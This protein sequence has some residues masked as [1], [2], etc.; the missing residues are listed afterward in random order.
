MEGKRR[1]CRVYGLFRFILSFTANTLSSR[2]AALPPSC[3]ASRSTTFALYLLPSLFLLLSSWVY[4][5]REDVCTMRKVRSERILDGNG[6]TDRLSAKNITDRR[7]GPAAVS[8]SPDRHSRCNSR[9]RDRAIAFSFSSVPFRIVL[10]IFGLWAL[11]THSY[12][13]IDVE[14]SRVNEFRMGTMTRGRTRPCNFN[15]ISV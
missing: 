9:T 15:F 3:R 7:D 4:S 10:G 2:R 13:T 12:G 1:D 5:L 11:T 8:L 14:D 6:A